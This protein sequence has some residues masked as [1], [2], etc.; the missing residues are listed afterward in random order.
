MKSAPRLNVL[1]ASYAEAGDF[2]KAVATQ[3]KAI[4]LLTDKDK[5]LK[6]SME[7]RIALYRAEQPFRDPSG[8][9]PID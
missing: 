3:E 8:R 1:A 4:A 9:T 6:A 5:E 7:R 2:G